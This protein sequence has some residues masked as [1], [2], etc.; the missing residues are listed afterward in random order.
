MHLLLDLN[1]TANFLIATRRLVLPQLVSLSIRIIES[2]ATTRQ[3]I[4][5]RLH[6]L[7][8]II[9]AY[10]GLIDLHL[11]NIKSDR[12]D[13]VGWSSEFRVLNLPKLQRLIL[14]SAPVSLNWITVDIRLPLLRHLSVDFGN[15]LF[16]QNM[17]GQL[18]GTSLL[19]LSTRATLVINLPFWTTFSALQELKIVRSSVRAV[20]CNTPPPALHPIRR[21]II[22]GAWPSNPDH[23][24]VN[25]VDRLFKLTDR[26]SPVEYVI[27]EDE[28]I[29]ALN[30]TQWQLYKDTI[31][32]H[33]GCRTLPEVCQQVMEKWVTSEDMDEDDPHRLA[34]F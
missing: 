29:N 9:K 4:S 20:M 10:P 2:S 3:F 11:H 31:L 7:P 34:L 26:P 23:A 14:H 28:C 32:S 5:A 12:H 21:V 25:T 24:P 18:L 30:Q 15:D 16:L 22:Q 1:S 33:A 8:I 13:F 17:I 19:T 6:I 27:C